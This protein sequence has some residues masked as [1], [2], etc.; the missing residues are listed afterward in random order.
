MSGSDKPNIPSKVVAGAGG[1]GG[2]GVR[3]G[4]VRFL[5]VVRLRDLF[6]VV[7]VRAPAFA[8]MTRSTR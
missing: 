1:G 4:D 2:G 3:F 6:G 5:P 7:F 8:N